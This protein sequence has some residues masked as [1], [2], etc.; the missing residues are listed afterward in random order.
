VSLPDGTIA[1]EGETVHLFVDRAT[2]RPT[3]APPPIRT[4][5]AGFAAG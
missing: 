5:L 3:S 2:G 1:V 4:A